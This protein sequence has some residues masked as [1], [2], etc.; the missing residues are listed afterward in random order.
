MPKFE[1]GQSNSDAAPSEPL[2]P[3]NQEPKT[4]SG[5]FK[6]K[7]RV[8]VGVVLIVI[9]VVCFQALATQLAEMSGHNLLYVAGMVSVF[10]GM[11]VLSVFGAVKVDAEHVDA[12]YRWVWI[13]FA[14]F[15]CFDAL[16][17]SSTMGLTA[18]LA[19]TAFMVFL[20]RRIA[21]SVHHGGD[22]DHAT[23]GEV[24]KAEP[25]AEKERMA[26]TT[27]ERLA[28]LEQ[29]RDETKAE[30]ARAKR[31]FRRLVI[32]GMVIVVCVAVLLWAW[33][34]SSEVQARRFVLVDQNGKV[35]TE[36][37]IRPDGGPALRLFDQNG[38]ARVG[39]RV[40]TDGTAGI[41]LCDQN[42]KIR[43]QLRI[44]A[45][46][47]LGLILADENGKNRAVLDVHKDGPWLALADDNG[48]LRAELGVGKEGPKLVLYNKNGETG[49]TL[50]ATKDG[51]VLF[52]D[53]ENGETRLTLGATKDGSGLFLDDENGKL[54]AEL[55]VGK[56]GA[57]AN[58]L[59]ANGKAIWSAP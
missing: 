1:S 57:R 28:T 32:P 59:D 31:R 23:T 4:D 44:L 11:V 15:G 21:A 47:N 22:Q 18:V 20:S 39:L 33:A 6:G 50:S 14:V 29:E 25:K 13:L 17:S 43:G 40:M 45:D 46:G 26:M 30:L 19:G 55:G 52:L 3:A 24:P 10:A 9:A 36:L 16:K 42:E 53:D 2:P 7:F 49:T 48:K 12:E 51:S 37:S 27:E 5:R 38:K 8:F 35:R 54:R 41:M 34:R 58:L 56:D